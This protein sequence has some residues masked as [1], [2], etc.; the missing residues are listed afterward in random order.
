MEQSELVNYMGKHLFF[1]IKLYLISD[2][3][4]GFG[5]KFGVQTDRK[6]DVS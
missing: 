2:Y 5:G 3:S 1:Y 6:D 4:K